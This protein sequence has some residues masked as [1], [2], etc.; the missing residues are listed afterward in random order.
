MFERVTAELRTEVYNVFNRNNYITL[1]NIYGE[2]TV[3]RAT[4][5][6]PIAGIANTDPSRQIHFALK[7]MF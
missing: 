7:V 5:L 3:P 4:F 2:G 6:Q 1:N